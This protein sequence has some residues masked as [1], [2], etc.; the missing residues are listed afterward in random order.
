MMPGCGALGCPQEGTDV[1]EVVIPP[2]EIPAGMENF[3]T[4]VDYCPAHAEVA[5]ANAARG[6][7][8]GHYPAFRWVSKVEA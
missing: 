3:D 4:S 6:V 5:L 2:E 7:G 1:L 8:R